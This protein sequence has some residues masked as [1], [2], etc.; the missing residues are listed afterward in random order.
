MTT[1]EKAEHLYRQF[2]K[3]EGHTCRECMHFRR[4]EY[5]RT[6]FKCRVF[7]DTGS[8]ATD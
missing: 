4:H 8:N 1:R 6:Y 5:A 3:C 7:G 2:G